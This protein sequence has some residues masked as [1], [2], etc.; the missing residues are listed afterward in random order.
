MKDT[1]FM[2]MSWASARKCREETTAMVTQ[3][4]ISGVMPVHNEEEYLRYSLPPLKTIPF[5]EL[6]FVLDR[7]TDNSEQII[8]NLGLSNSRIVNKLKQRWTYSFAETFQSGF[9]AAENDLVFALGA[10]LIIT[11]EAFAKTRD[12]MR[13]PK[14][15]GIFFGFIR[16]PIRGIR[17]R[18]HE[19]YINFMKHFLLDSFSPYRTEFATGVYCFRRSLAKLRDV[20]V[21][22][23]DLRNQIQTNGYEAVYVARAG[24]IHLR[25]GL[26]TEK[27]IW[28]GK[29]RAKLHEPLMKVALHSI[30]NVKP[31]T[32]VT[33]LR[34]RE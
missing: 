26:S 8:R 1:G 13:D 9:D 20:P 5:D 29:V 22:Y 12:V 14:V 4:K 25:T 10:D 24:I 28:H 15:G 17:R 23:I 6:V 27:Q 19:E 21:E 30:I 18:F 34:C 31:W 11:P 33:F 2:V 32:L 7:C 3:M 16:R